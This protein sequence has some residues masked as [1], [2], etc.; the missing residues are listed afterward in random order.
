MV[1]IGSASFSITD[2]IV[3]RSASY[4]ISDVKKPIT[5]E[6]VVSNYQQQP[7]TTNPTEP[8][9]LTQPMAIKVPQLSP[10]VS[11]IRNH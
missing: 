6:V 9:S 5:K 7:T 8:L 1:T 3:I 11:I 4:T 10:G 2:I